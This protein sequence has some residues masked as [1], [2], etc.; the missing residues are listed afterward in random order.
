MCEYF[1]LTLI[2]F[3]SKIIICNQIF[4]SID[5][6]T[7]NFGVWRCLMAGRKPKPLTD[8]PLE[9]LHI[10]SEKERL[11]YY[12]CKTNHSIKQ[13]SEKL[14]LAQSTVRKF[15]QR[16]REKALQ[17]EFVYKNKTQSPGAEPALLTEEFRELEAEQIKELMFSYNGNR[18]TA[19]QDA[20][21]ALL[22][23]GL[24]LKQSASVMGKSPQAVKSLRNR[25]K[26]KVDPNEFVSVLKKIEVRK[27]HAK[28]NPITLISHR[29][30]FNYTLDELSQKTNI[31]KQ[32][33]HNIEKGQIIPNRED[34]IKIC[35]ALSL[36]AD[37]Y[38]FGPS[39][40]KQLLQK[41]N[42]KIFLS[43]VQGHNGDPIQRAINNAGS[44]EILNKKRSTYRNKVMY[45]GMSGIG[46]H[47]KMPVHLTKEQ[48]RNCKHYL[49]QLSLK[50]AVIN[51]F[52]E[53]AIFIMTQAQRITVGQ[54]LS[55]V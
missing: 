28:Y 37:D 3:N 15:M 54:I 30:K 6:Y 11:I 55:V 35:D 41:L 38:I 29:H 7:H 9:K 53:T 2:S 33:L 27:Y 25:A 31:K 12:Y 14:N 46:R 4:D 23:N 32:T 10:L 40:A 24:T 19:Q 45:Y 26:K 51:H 8:I 18:L 50:P 39:P 20:A 47:G 13:L 16:I 49:D 48:R 52:G 34:L 22:G 5:M 44:R 21:L 43:M 17:I 42:D 1:L 36:D